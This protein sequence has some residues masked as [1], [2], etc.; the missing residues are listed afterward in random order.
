MSSSS[1]NPYEP[2]PESEADPDV[3][4]WRQWWSSVRR[5]RRP[6]RFGDARI[7][8]EGVLFFEQPSLDTHFHAA[9][10]LLIPS[11][12]KAERCIQEVLR[13]LPGLF[14]NDKD[15]FGRLNDRPLQVHF[16]NSYRQD[17]LETYPSVLIHIRMDESLF[18]S[19]QTSTDPISSD[20]K[21]GESP[22]AKE[23][24]T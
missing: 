8:Y 9:I 5:G 14:R 10:P 4:W 24:S 7:N 22:F 1:P 3:P 19:A 2:P 6:R 11:Q 21:P 16:V 23:L 20:I 12:Q 18:G 17:A 15:L 13:L